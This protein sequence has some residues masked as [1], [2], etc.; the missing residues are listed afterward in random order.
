[1]QSYL[2]SIPSIDKMVRCQKGQSWMSLSVA[3]KIIKP[4]VPGPILRSYQRRKQTARTAKFESTRAQVAH[5]VAAIAAL[6]AEQRRNT[7]FLEHEFIPQVIGLNDECLDEQPSEFAP[8]YGTGLHVW[9]YPNQLAGY[10]A[11]LSDNASDIG[12]YMEI[13][14]RWG[15]T[16]IL[17]AEWVRN[18]SDRLRS[19]SAIDPIDPT[20]FIGEYFAILNRAGVETAY[21]Q[22][23]STTPSAKA[24]VDQL[25]PEF[26]FIDGDHRL[27]GAMSDHLLVRPHAKIIAH[28][29]ISSWSE[30][31]TTFLWNSLKVLEA[32][33]FEFVEFVEQ[34]QSVG[35][36]FLGIGAMRR[37]E[38]A[39]LHRSAVR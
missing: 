34:Y 19:V 21:V 10:L 27:Q 11:W 29:D 14:P 2:Q 16:F 7:R 32:Q 13:G 17:V 35:G 26:V 9:Q 23:F 8:F 24:A 20:P 22:E 4:F 18:T 33:Q 39:V 30:P 3:R 31:D 1:M 36:Q 6:D 5:V 28:H 25:R 15:G 37:R 38:S 12:S